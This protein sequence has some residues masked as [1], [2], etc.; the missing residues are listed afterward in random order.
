MA[1]KTVKWD[2][3]SRARTLRSTQPR[4]GDAIKGQGDFPEGGRPGKQEGRRKEKYSK[5]VEK[6]R[7]QEAMRL[8]PRPGAGSQ[9][10]LAAPFSAKQSPIP[11]LPPED[12]R[13]STLPSVAGALESLLRSPRSGSHKLPRAYVGWILFLPN[14]NNNRKSR[15]E[16]EKALKGPVGVLGPQRQGV[17]VPEP[18]S[19]PKDHPPGP[20]IPFDPSRRPRP[21]S[22]P[23]PCDPADPDPQPPGPLRNLRPPLTP[24]PPTS[25]TRRHTPARGTR[26][27]ARPRVR[28]QRRYLRR[29]GPSGPPQRRA[30]SGAR[31][32][33]APRQPAAPTASTPPPPTPPPLQPG[34]GA[35]PGPAAGEARPSRPRESSGT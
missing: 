2:K 7:R 24:Q 8:P 16:T 25:P 18:G 28:R 33:R 31:T 13:V 32:R 34:G 20:P 30:G 27:P 15:G 11:P 35:G 29:D 12:T 10:L 6:T 19:E 1:R 26:R 4:L 14:Q 21:P 17:L 5:H 3:Q 22:T 9:V 23:G